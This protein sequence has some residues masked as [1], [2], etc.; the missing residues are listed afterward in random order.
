M[1]EVGRQA[2]QTGWKFRMLR[3]D[4]PWLKKYR[5][6]SETTPGYGQPRFVAR[7]QTRKATPSAARMAVATRKLA[8]FRDVKEG[9]AVAHAIGP[10]KQKTEKRP[11]EKH[12]AKGEHRFAS[13]LARCWIRRSH[14]SESTFVNQRRARSNYFVVQKASRKYWSIVSL[15]LVLVLKFV[16]VLDFPAAFEGPKRGPFGNRQCSNPTAP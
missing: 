13:G 12:D 7:D 9:L 5:A 1:V 3:C 11:G 16:L 4:I 15:Q 2:D 6:T 14:G 10:A 8:G